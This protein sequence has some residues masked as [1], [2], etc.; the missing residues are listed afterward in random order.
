[1]WQLSAIRNPLREHHSSGK[2]KQ[3]CNSCRGRKVRCDRHHPTCGRSARLGTNCTYESPSKPSISKSDLPHLLYQLH[4]RLEQAE[5]RLACGPPALNTAP[6]NAQI[7]DAVMSN[8]P[9]FNMEFTTQDHFS[10]GHES[11]PCLTSSEIDQSV[12]TT[13]SAPQTDSNDSFTKEPSDVQFDGMDSVTATDPLRLGLA[14]DSLD[15][16]NILATPEL[17]QLVISTLC[18][19]FFGVFHP[20]LSYAMGALGA[21]AFPKL[22]IPL[23]AC[24]HQARHLLDLCER[25]EDKAKFADIRMVQACI[26]LSLYELRRPN[27]ARAWVTLGRAIRLGQVISLDT[28]EN[29]TEGSFCP[30]QFNP[31]TPSSDPEELEERRRTFWLLYLLDSYTVMRTNLSPFFHGRQINIPLPSPLSLTSTAEGCNLPTLEQAFEI[32]EATNLSAFAGNIMVASIYRRCLDHMTSWTQN[33]CFDSHKADRPLSIILRVNLAAV[34]IGL[35]ETAI[36][37]V[38]NE[39]LPKS[40]WNEAATKCQSASQEIEEG[41]RCSMRLGAPE[42]TII[43]QSSVFYTWALTKAIAVQVKVLEHHQNITPAR[44]NGLRALTKLT[45]ELT[46]PEHVSLK[47]LEQVDNKLAETETLRK[48]RGYQQLSGF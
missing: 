48:K 22:G 19:S 14:Q 28:S 45:R 26:L 13:T 20:T 24:Y 5:A 18:S 7:P 29:H 27:P 6:Y 43:R 46:A 31:L 30:G 42:S 4:S 23:E 38:E 3:P 9:S 44:I 11:I 12:P 36:A 15:A 10:F 21:L 37:K 8:I 16:E 47:L 35:H 33:L 25:Q 39:Q 34:A 17:L 32:Q 1:M 41:M 40:L 2:E